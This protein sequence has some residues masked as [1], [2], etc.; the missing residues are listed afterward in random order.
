M[1]EP[2]ARIPGPAAGQPTSA[3]RTP[4]EPDAPT[5]GDANIAIP[6][7]HGPIVSVALPFFVK[8]I[9]PPNVPLP[10]KV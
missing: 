9:N 7:H 8:V 3:Q 4:F 1:T 10:P 5:I 2:Q 6:T